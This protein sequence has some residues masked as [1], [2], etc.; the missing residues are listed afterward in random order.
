MASPR[1]RRPVC[2][3]AGGFISHE[4]IV[5]EALTATVLWSWEGYSLTS[6]YGADACITRTAPSSPCCALPSA[7][8]R[9]LTSGLTLN[10]SG[11][12]TRL[13]RATLAPRPRLTTKGLATGSN[14]EFSR[15]SATLDAFSGFQDALDAPPTNLR[16]VLGSFHPRMPTHAAELARMV[17]AATMLLWNGLKP[18]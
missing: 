13:A 2:K 5:H 16:N 7:A 10:Q 9:V 18:V 1:K 6:V 15:S 11:S 4:D 17:D 14:R 12:G 8:F 3:W